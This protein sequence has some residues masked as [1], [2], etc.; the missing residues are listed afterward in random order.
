[1]TTPW[2]IFDEPYP[3]IREIGSPREDHRGSCV[4][5]RDYM[6]RGT[7]ESIVRAVNCHEELQQLAEAVAAHFA[8]TDAPLGEQARAVLAKARG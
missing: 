4:L 2:A 1:M 5:A 3:H 6:P 7:L 8:G